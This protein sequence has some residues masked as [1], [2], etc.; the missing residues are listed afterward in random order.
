MSIVTPRKA[1]TLDASSSRR[2]LF[3]LLR[4]VSIGGGGGPAGDDVLFSF[5]GL[6]H[7]CVG[8]GSGDAPLECVVAHVVHNVS[9]GSRALSAYL[10]L[11][12]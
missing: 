1:E 6:G 2:E 12:A 5:V 4:G 9:L 7:C 3:C 11:A 10:V 8:V